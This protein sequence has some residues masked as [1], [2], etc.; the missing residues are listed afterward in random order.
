[1][2]NIDETIKEWKQV[3][4]IQNSVDGTEHHEK[5]RYSDILPYSFNS[6]KIDN[7]IN[8]SWIDIGGKDVIVCQ[9]PLPNTFYDF[10]KMVIMY[11][12]ECIFMLTNLKENGVIKSHRYWPSTN[13]PQIIDDIKIEIVESSII[14]KNITKTKIK[15]EYQNSEK[16]VDHIHYTGWSD[17]KLPSS[18]N[19]IKHL[20]N[21]YSND[22]NYIIHCS[23][24]CG[25]SGVFC[26]ILRYL[27]THE[28]S[29]EIL[30]K[31]RA[32][33]MYMINNIY[34]YIYLKKFISEN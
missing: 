9:S 19:D 3:E 7:Y 31:L 26:G 23:A 22:K 32:Q 25:R 13:I 12:I 14:N 8:A 6:V 4:N 33:R 18:H 11:N 20:L 15:L 24:G 5:N 21:L 34:Q 1:M 17:Y 29:I 27:N 30:T 28:S 10:W 16:Y 2:E